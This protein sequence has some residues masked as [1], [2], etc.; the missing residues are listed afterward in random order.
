LAPRAE[1]FLAAGLLIFF[2]EIKEIK[3][4]DAQT[5]AAHGISL[6]ICQCSIGATRLGPGSRLKIQDL[7]FSRQEPQGQCR[8]LLAPHPELRQAR[9]KVF[10]LLR[11]SMRGIGKN[12]AKFRGGR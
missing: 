5:R 9:K 3:R 11:N 10:G 8:K 6:C 2:P 12:V 7:F 4:T 1:F